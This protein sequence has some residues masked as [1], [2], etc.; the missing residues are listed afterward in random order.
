MRKH[1][2][3]LEYFLVPFATKHLS[4]LVT[5]WSVTEPEEK[6]SLGFVVS[7]Y[8]NVTTPEGRHSTPLKWGYVA[9]QEGL[10]SGIECI[11]NSRDEAGNAL[12]Q[13]ARSNEL[14]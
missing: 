14:F 13:E 5:I 12:V 8:R 7:S 1:Q 2:N 11:Y 9:Y 10:I 4:S 3:V 6:K